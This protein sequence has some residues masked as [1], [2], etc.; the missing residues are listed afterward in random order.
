MKPAI[1]FDFDGTLFFGTAA[2]NTWCFTRALQTMGLSEATGEKIAMSVGMTFQNV[3]RLMTESEKPEIHA[4]FEEL[5][6]LYVPS[7]IEAHVRPD[8]VVHGMLA[9]LGKQA[10]L[11]V[12]SNA[13]ASYLNPMLGALGLTP[14]FDTIWAYHN[15]Y[16][17]AT[18]IPEVL[19]LLGSERGVFV[20]D[21]LEDVLAAREAGIPVVGI[22]NAAYPAET[23]GADITVENHV[24]MQA[25]IETLL[26]RR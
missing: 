12:C 26:I 9:A 1:L 4:Q 24:Q 13:A 15:N 6:F 7:Y 23:D 2:L 19:R 17:K 20:G 3:A 25:A 5:T 8:P 16:R 21:R 14:F 18:A 22:R 11:A 10:R